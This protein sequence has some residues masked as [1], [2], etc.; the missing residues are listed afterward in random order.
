MFKIMKSERH[1]SLECS[2]NIFKAKRHLLIRE[3]T[4]RTYECHFMLILRPDMDL[5]IAQ[6][7]IHEGEYFSSCTL[8]DNMID[9][10]G[11]EVVFWTRFIHIMKFHTNMNGSFLFI[12]W[13]GI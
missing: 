10:W 5:I 4:P 9:K 3:S 1:S 8:I 6:K 12:H 11:G 7:S 13:N 2:P